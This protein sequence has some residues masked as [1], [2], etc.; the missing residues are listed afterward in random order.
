MLVCCIG[1]YE[2]LSKS[3]NPSSW[4]AQLCQARST[5]HRKVL[6]SKEIVQLTQ[7]SSPFPDG[8]SA[9]SDP[10]RFFG[11]YLKPEQTAAPLQLAGSALVNLVPGSE[12]NTAVI[13]NNERAA[14]LAPR[15]KKTP[16]ELDR[17]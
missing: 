17:V 11:G 7:V 3:A 2:K 1:P 5:E 15:S 14:W 16:E 8:W 13:R 4:L 9:G 10:G 12:P 6:E